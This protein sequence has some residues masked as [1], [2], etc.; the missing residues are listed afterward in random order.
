MNLLDKILK[1]TVLS[2]FLIACEDPGDLGLQ[3]DPGDSQTEVKFQEFVLP[4]STFYIDSM[5]TD[6]G[7][8]ILVGNNTDS[9]YGHVAS[10][11]FMELVY[12]SGQTPV[13]CLDVVSGRLTFEISDILSLESI[14]V[15]HLEVRALTDTIFPSRIYDRM[16]EIPT[17]EGLVADTWTFGVDAN[18]TIVNFDLGR[19]FVNRLWDLTENTEDITDLSLSLNLRANDESNGMVAINIFAD[20][21]ELIINSKDPHDSIY[22]TVYTFQ[23][24]FNQV[25]RDRSGSRIESLVETG[26]SLSVDNGLS[27]LNGAA[28]T[29]V[30][31][32]M[33]PF[34]DFINNNDNIIINKADID[35]P[36]Y[37]PVNNA[38][39][40]PIQ[41]IS[42]YFYKDGT[43]ING[44]GIAQ[45]VLN[46]AVLP[47]NDYQSLTALPVPRSI[48]YS[49]DDQLYTSTVTLFSQSLIT[50]KLSGDEFLT[51]DLVVVPAT[52][53][54]IGQTSIQ[55]SGIKLKVF[56]TTVK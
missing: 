52:W 37:T 36:V 2:L 10:Q 31:L 41:D 8:N 38:I 54:S 55:N 42:L 17:E 32:R 18:D 40:T 23:N 15:L 48:F 11:S 24:H 34:L 4:A 47:E 45:D 56:Y 46:T 26:D 13:D 29:V 20:T 21:T 5:R 22:S 49:E 27:Y 3:L 33:Q 39:Q 19:G 44:P 7:S 6:R 9:V 50:D 35:I 1:G 14:S 51:E 30:K 16:D 53:V 28:G 25:D 43:V 12:S